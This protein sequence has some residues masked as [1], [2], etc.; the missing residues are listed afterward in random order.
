[1]PQA[2]SSIRWAA[3]NKRIV[4]AADMLLDGK[5]RIVRNMRI[6]IDGSKIAGLD[7][8]AGRRL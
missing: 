6:V 7:T 2:R 1:L 5:S 3:P 8:K 4:I